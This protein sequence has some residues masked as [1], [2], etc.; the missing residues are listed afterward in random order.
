MAY[1][2][3]GLFLISAYAPVNKAPENEWEGYFDK[4]ITCLRRKRNKDI[5]VIGTDCNSSMGCKSG[6]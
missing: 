3:V 4:L 5:I 6:R 2:D 1:E